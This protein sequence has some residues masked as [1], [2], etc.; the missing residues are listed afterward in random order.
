MV[1]KLQRRRFRMKC[2]PFTT[3]Y[4]TYYIY[5]CVVKCNLQDHLSPVGIRPRNLQKNETIWEQKLIKRAANFCTEFNSIV[6]AIFRLIF[7]HSAQTH[8]LQPISSVNDKY[9]KGAPDFMSRIDVYMCVYGCQCMS[10]QSK[11]YCNHINHLIAR[12]R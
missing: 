2:I 12:E 5:V 9:E 8:T 10:L 3:Y 7:M 1:W 4:T 6:L 11:L